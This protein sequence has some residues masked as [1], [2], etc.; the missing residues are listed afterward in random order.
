M[1]Y[2]K[3]VA[4]VLM[5]ALFAAC[6]SGKKET[7][8][9]KEIQ[10]KDG[11]PIKVE[12]VEKE[13]LSIT[14]K[15]SGTLR[16]KKEAMAASAIGGNVEEIFVRVGQYVKKD[17]NIAKFRNDA[18][19]SQYRQAKAAYENGKKNLERFEELFNAGAISKQQLD[20]IR[21]MH[22]VN[23]ANFEAA[24]KQIFVKAPIAGYVAD[25]MVNKGDGIRFDTPVASITD[26]NDMSIKINVPE[27]DIKYID[28]GNEVYI[29]SGGEKEEKF[30]GNISE[31]SLTAN[32]MTRSFEVEIDID[33]PGKSLR[34][35]SI[36][37]VEIALIKKPNSISTIRE[38]IKEDKAGKEYVYI[39]DGN[40]AK[41]K[42]IKTG[43]KYGTD[44]EI[45]EGLSEG[46]LLV[47][48]GS[49]LLSDGALVKIVEES[50]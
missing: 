21:T 10:E 11:I 13:T 3:I 47:V 20:E 18:P 14:K 38:V 8:K 27:A 32:P 35:G 37:E 45:K 42:Y 46:D 39:V 43:F 5:I 40:K 25:I 30:S 7:V 4:A 2:Y 34:S 9:I 16:G 41:K 28:G 44:V 49:S 33:K 22:E 29:L 23:K 50:K 31:V 15:Y 24:E 12:K 26:L 1:K 48:S 17:Q 19:S 36:V 6:D